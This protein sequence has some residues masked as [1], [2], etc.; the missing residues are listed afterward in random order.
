[1]A[2]YLVAVG[3]FNRESFACFE[4][5]KTYRRQVYDRIIK[6]GVT[7]ERDV[8][9]CRRPADSCIGPSAYLPSKSST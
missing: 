2:V 1:M 4:W 3:M 6:T 8:D 9:L 7:M 5:M